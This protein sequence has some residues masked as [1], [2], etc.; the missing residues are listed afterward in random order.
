[1]ATVELVVWDPVE[2]VWRWTLTRRDG[3]RASGTTETRAVAEIELSVHRSPGPRLEPRR[4]R[5]PRPRLRGPA[6][7]R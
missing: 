3:S 1:M 6:V 5:T 4:T 7:E 2:R